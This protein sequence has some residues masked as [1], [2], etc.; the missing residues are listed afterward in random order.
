MTDTGIERRTCRGASP[1]RP[2]RAGGVLCVLLGVRAALF[3]S[4]ADP[5]CAL[6]C[7]CRGAAAIGTDSLRGVAWAR[8]T[9][10]GLR[11]A[12]HPGVIEGF[13]D[14]PAR[15]LR[16]APLLDAYDVTD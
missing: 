4:A 1:A 15:R 8:R 11:Q 7:R 2:G 3:E 14:R 5:A 10:S 6:K 12:A 13:G 9:G 16:E